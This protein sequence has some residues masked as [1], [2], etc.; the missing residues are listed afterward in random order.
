[1]TL[2]FKDFSYQPE[3]WWDYTQYDE[4]DRFSKM[5]MLGHFLRVPRNVEISRI[6]K[7]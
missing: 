1:M 3:I 5:A 7:D 6:D 2:S 4:A